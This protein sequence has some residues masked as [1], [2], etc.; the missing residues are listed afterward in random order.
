MVRV[1]LTT[2]GLQNRCSATELHRHAR[3]LSAL[4]YTPLTPSRQAFFHITVAEYSLF[5]KNQSLRI[6]EM[7][8]THPAAEIST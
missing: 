5:Y 1:E 6:R 2:N 7:N 4:D 8:P 3:Q